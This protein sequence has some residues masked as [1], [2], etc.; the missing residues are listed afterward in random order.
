MLPINTEWRHIRQ[1]VADVLAARAGRR[2]EGK[3]DHVSPTRMLIRGVV[4]PK[5]AKLGRRQVEG[6]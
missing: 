4:L 6:R 3:D 5:G 1:D 2:H